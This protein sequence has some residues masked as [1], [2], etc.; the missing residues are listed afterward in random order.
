MRLGQRGQMLHRP[1]LLVQSLAQEPPGLF[2]ARFVTFGSIMLRPHLSTRRREQFL[3]ELIAP[4]TP[5]SAKTT[6]ISSRFL[7]PALFHPQSELS[8]PSRAVFG[9]ART[10]Q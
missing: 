10:A 6:V 7:K 3:P 4:Q 1:A 8:P 5:T 2:L 9:N